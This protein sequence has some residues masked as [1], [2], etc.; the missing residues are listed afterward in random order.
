MAACKLG[1]IR[2]RAFFSE[3]KDA[4]YHWESKDALFLLGTNGDLDARSVHIITIYTMILL[5]ICLSI[6]HF[7][8]QEMSLV[9]TTEVY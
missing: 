3:Y 9:P 2:F 4:I 1:L 6:L 5:C 7:V 8:L